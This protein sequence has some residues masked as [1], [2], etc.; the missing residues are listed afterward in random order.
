MR[1]AVCRRQQ[2]RIV[3]VVRDNIRKN[4]HNKSVAKAMDRK[5]L[6]FP[7]WTSR[8][9]LPNWR[10]S[11]KSWLRFFFDLFADYCSRTFT[12]RVDC[13]QTQRD[14]PSYRLSN[15]SKRRPPSRVER[16]RGRRK[17]IFSYGND[18]RY[19]RSVKSNVSSKRLTKYNYY[20]RKIIKNNL[21]VCGNKL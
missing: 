11:K 12:A 15:R 8:T 18:Y 6:R 21:W 5:Q 7:T 14:F 9:A 3:I 19:R 1:L 13:E 10:V 17:S 20:R 16:G 2:R 4:T